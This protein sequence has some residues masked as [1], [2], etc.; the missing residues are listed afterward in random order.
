MLSNTATPKY[1]G[2]FR[3][4]V[5]NEEIEVPETVSMQMNI[6]DSL[7]DDPNYYYDG[8][9][10]EGFI[11]FCENELCLTDGSPLKLLDT[12]KLWAEDVLG[13]YYYVTRSVYEPNENGR[14]GHYVTKKIK[15]RLRNEQY[16]ILARGGAK[17]MYASAH[18]LYGLVVDKATTSAIVTAPTMVQGEIILSP[19]RT[20]IARAL[21]PVFKFMT[22]G[23]LQNTTGN[24]KDRVKLASTKKGIENFLTNSSITI[25][26]MKIDAL[27][28]YSNKYAAIDEWL[29]GDTRENPFE[30]IRQGASKV[31]DY[32]IIATSSE[33]TVRN[34]V[35]DSVKMELTKILRGEIFNPHVSIWWYKLDDVKEVADPD[36][37]VKA[38][39]N[40]G[41]TVKYETYQNEVERAEISPAHRNDILAKRFGIPME[42]YTYYFPYEETVRFQ[43]KEYWKMG[44]SL[45]IDLSQGDDFCAF[46]FLFPLRNG[47]FGI[48]TRAYISE[49]TL[50][51]L[52][53]AM[54]EKYN[55]FIQ[56][57]TV[58][59]MNGTVLD[60]MEVYEDLINFIDEMEYEV[61]SVGYDPYFAKEFIE[62]WCK[63]NGDYGVVKVA[64]GAR[65]ESVP[66]GEIKKLSEDR[67]L[68]FDESLMSFSIGN[69]IVL[70]DTNGNRKLYKKRREEKIDNVAALL[71]AFIAYKAYRELFD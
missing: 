15:Y 39:P 48:K 33:G 16:L 5:L 49:R 31:D 45:G 23:S 25:K 19:M 40:I 44:C 70:E 26:P 68:L 6:I 42:G 69:C 50:F 47:S 54:R 18:M 65:T 32:L 34:G 35:G 8:E 60:M 59:V 51:T 14:G 22:M 58:I 11:Q 56:E 43:K 7:I 10:V 38:Q 27:Q 71:D 61:Y 4:K 13:W 21:G 46:T 20:A 57:G 52:S 55:E 30:A 36:M 67:M 64:Q 62:R 9:V 37:W 41:H 3:R 29:S 17:S 2:E 12:F 28:G 63:E 66:L 53:P 24:K 1:Y